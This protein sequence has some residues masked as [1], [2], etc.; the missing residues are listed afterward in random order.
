MSLSSSGAGIRR[1]AGKSPAAITL[2]VI[3]ALSRRLAGLAEYLRDQARST[4]DAQLPGDTKSLFHGALPR[5]STEQIAL[6]ALYCQNACEHRFPL[7]GAIPSVVELG[8]TYPGWRNVHFPPEQ[9]VSVDM[10]GTWLDNQITAVN[11]PVARTIWSAIFSGPYAHY[12]YK[13]IDWQVDYRTGYHWNPRDHFSAIRVGDIRGVDIKMPWELSRLQ[14]LPRLA[15]L[16][17][18]M[19]GANP[20]AAHKLAAEIRAQLLDFIARNPPRFGVNW[21]AIM[22]TAIRGANIA[23]TL[24][25]LESAGLQF[26]K[27]SKATIMT[28]L[29]AHVRHVLTHLEWSEETRG[30]HYLANVTGIL[31][32][33]AALPDS[34]WRSAVLAFAADQFDTEITRQFLNDGGSFEG[35]TAYHRLSGEMALWGSALL[36][37]L[38]AREPQI[39]SSFDP[40]LIRPRPGMPSP[41]LSPNPR[42]AGAPLSDQT[43]DRLRALAVF[44]SNARDATGN[45]I[46]IGDDDSGRFF[47]LQLPGQNE[48]RPN[49]RNRDAMLAMAD[50]LFGGPY[51]SSEL[52]PEVNVITALTG[53]RKL[54]PPASR[55]RSSQT[56]T[57][58]LS[59]FVSCITALPPAS[60]RHFHIPWPSGRPAELKSAAHEDFGLFLYKAQ[61]FSLTIRCYIPPA[62]DESGHT[63]DDNLSIDLMIEEK[64]FIRDP[65]V[66]CYTPFP[67]LRRLYQGIDAHF[68]PR[69]AGHPA[70][71]YG[72]GCFSVTHLSKGN[73]LYFNLDGFAGE[74]T[75]P[76]WHVIR[77]IRLTDEGISIDDGSLH[78]PLAEYEVMKSPILVCRGYGEET[79]S[80]ACSL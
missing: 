24:S 42:A 44:A 74:L 58:P 40:A 19:V 38:A 46:L 66:F 9:S 57:A 77:T 30:N 34:S 6:L 20:G 3:Q 52:P 78:G 8:A 69:A 7:L 45:A 18:A 36:I 26:D 71:A 80:P 70:I 29:N 65:G 47:D 11:L 41:P 75:G 17:H 23:L 61:G 27:L 21:R 59:E 50:T 67:E 79:D 51:S 14:H 32:M 25:L 56:S 12:D 55:R 73:C 76:G 49:R 48:S 4:F 62:P 2:R 31:F 22:D 35:S 1:L 64:P 68:A 63:H 13:P 39:F 43:L 53:G 72:A 60:Q 10:S 15:L 5:M 28:S 37:G 16:I 54:N 33:A